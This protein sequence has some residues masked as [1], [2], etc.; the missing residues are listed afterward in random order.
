LLLNTARA[1]QFGA[2]ATAVLS[3][4]SCR[5]CLRVD[6]LALHSFSCFQLSEPYFPQQNYV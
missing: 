3:Q 5:L 2:M 6:L 4:R 1:L